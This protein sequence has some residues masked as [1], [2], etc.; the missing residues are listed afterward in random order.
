MKSKIYFS[1]ARAKGYDY[2]YSFVAKFEQI[3][4]MVNLRDLSKR[5]NT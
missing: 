3:L 5:A 1:D 4:E 2:K